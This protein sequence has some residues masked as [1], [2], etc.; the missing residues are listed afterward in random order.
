MEYTV[1][2]KSKTENTQP[3]SNMKARKIVL[4]IGFIVTFL[5]MLCALYASLALFVPSA[6]FIKNALPYNVICTFYIVSMSL[7]FVGLVLSVAGANTSKALARLSFFFGTVSF[8]VSA[9]FLVV[10]L[11]INFFPFGALGRLLA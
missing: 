4:L 2:M 1:N 9:G 11:L 3:Y 5:G 8:I 10:L 6:N 7:C